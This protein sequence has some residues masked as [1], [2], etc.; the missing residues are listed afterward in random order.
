MKEHECGPTCR[1]QGLYAP[2]RSEG[3]LKMFSSE[4]VAAC[5]HCDGMLCLTGH[6][7]HLP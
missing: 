1:Q 3:E 6:I 4:K 5:L 2:E 7:E